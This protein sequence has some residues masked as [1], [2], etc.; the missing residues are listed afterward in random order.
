LALEA[1]AVGVV[2]TSALTRR[3]GMFTAVDSVSFAVKAGEVFG[4]IGPNGAG[5]STLLKMLTTM[6]PPSSGRAQ[7]ADYNIARQPAQVRKHRAQEAADYLCALVAE[8]LRPS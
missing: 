3:F 6:L 4:L 7:V 8:K 2:V 1:E 5:K